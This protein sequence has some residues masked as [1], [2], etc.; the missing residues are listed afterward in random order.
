HGP[1]GIEN[2]DGTQAPACR[3]VLNLSGEPGRHAAPGALVER[4]VQL[5]PG[6]LAYRQLEVPALVAAADAPPQRDLVLDEVE[7]FSVEVGGA[8]VVPLRVRRPQALRLGQ[9]AQLG[10]DEVGAGVVLLL[11]FQVVALAARHVSQATCARRRT[12]WR[13]AQ[14]A[15][16]RWPGRPGRARPAT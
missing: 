1:F 12:S 15:A 6:V 5:L 8:Q 9:V 16:R 10:Q 14:L 2:G 4:R 11:G 3:D 7:V 13:A